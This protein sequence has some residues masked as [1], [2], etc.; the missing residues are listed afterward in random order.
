VIGLFVGA[1]VAL[2]LG[3]GLLAASLRGRPFRA[4][5]G[6]LDALVVLALP[7]IGALTVLGALALER[8]F[9]RRDPRPPETDPA[10][11]APIREVDPLEELRI[12]TAVAPFAEILALGD[13]EEVDRALR[14]LVDSERPAV[15]RLLKD[16]LQSPRL[17]VRVRVRGL[18]VRL[19]DRLRIRA[20]DA[21]DPVERARAARKLG[22]LSVDPATVRQQFAD[23]V[24]A[25]ED[26]LASRPDSAAGGELGQLL[27]LLGEA[28]R[29]R[30]VLTQHLRE[31]PDDLEARHARAR[32]SLRLADVPAV[33]RDCRTLDLPAP[34]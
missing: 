28:E 11:D 30:D 27:L 4:S 22:E 6:A 7:G 9:R 15:L 32:A 12:G 13:L 14:R 25:Y 8:L 10:D 23:A 16:A 29:A 2:A 34:E 20:R 31:H 17:E 21:D 5:R 18:L 19:E 24:R 1:H 33:R 26:A 3:L